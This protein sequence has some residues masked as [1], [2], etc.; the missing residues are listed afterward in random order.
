MV[1]PLISTGDPISLAGVELRLLPDG[2]REIELRIDAF[3][4]RKVPEWPLFLQVIRQL[5]RKRCGLLKTRAVRL[6]LFSVT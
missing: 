3:R 1:F 5:R 4:A 2:E 6:S